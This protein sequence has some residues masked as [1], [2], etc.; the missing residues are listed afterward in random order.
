MRPQATPRGGRPK[1]QLA[2]GEDERAAPLRL[3]RRGTV[4]RRTARRARI[5]L[6]C[7]GGSDNPAVARRLHVTPAAVGKWRGRFVGHRLDGLP[8]E[9]RCGTP[10]AVTDERVEA[11]VVRTPES[12]PRGQAHWGTR[13]MARAGG[14]GRS[15]VGRTWRASGLR[16]HRSETFTPSPDP[17]FVEKVRDVVGLH[18]NPPACAAVPCVDE[19]GPTRA[20]DRT[21]PLLPMAPGPAGRR[22]HDHVRHGTTSPFAA[23]DAATGAVVSRVHRRHRP[24]ESRKFLDATDASVPGGLDVHVVTDNHGTR[25]TPMTRRWF[26]KRPRSHAHFTPTCGSWPNLAERLFAEVTD[27]CVRRGSHRNA[28][29]PGAAI[30]GFP[31]ARNENPRPF[32]WGETADDILASIERFATRALTNHP[33]V[34]SRTSGAGH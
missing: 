21:R 16:P 25:K 9:P 11:V 4:A 10:R 19:K 13:E 34:S 30:R 24:A 2:L 20:P 8:D 29:A 1:P 3:V 18:L 5:V 23:L 27:T 26:A 22:T 6:A 7:A 33:E 12:V 14:L 31:E 28:A 32:V 15:A 17:Q